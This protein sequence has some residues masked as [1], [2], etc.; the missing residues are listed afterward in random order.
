MPYEIV[1]V[2]EI[3]SPNG[4]FK[5]LR[6]SLGVSAFGINQLEL[7]ANAEGP[8]HDHG[9]DGQEEVYAIVRG[10]G[11]IRVEGEERDLHPGQFVFLAPGTSRQMVAGPDGLAW[12]GIGCQPGAYKAP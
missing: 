9:E 5:P 4:V 11:A 10:A 7:P 12:I 8:E 1:D 6:P 3:E 2:S